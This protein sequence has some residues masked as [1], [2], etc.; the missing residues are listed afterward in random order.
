LIRKFRGRTWVFGDEINTDL[1]YPQL[2]YTLPEE[3]RPL[4]AMWANRPKWSRE[5]KHGDILVA[6]RN[7]GIGSSRPAATNLKSLGIACAIVESINGLFLRNAV[8]V[9]FLALEAPGISG[10]VKEGDVLE[11]DL[12]AGLVRDL[13]TN[14][15]I[16]LKPLPRFLIDLIEDGGIIERLR[17][18]KLLSEDPL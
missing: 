11:V 16:G 18:R 1:M 9:G 14:S 17:K 13:E 5:V 4:Y 12:E 2:C 8:N 6:G 3:N 7:F 15:S 10:L